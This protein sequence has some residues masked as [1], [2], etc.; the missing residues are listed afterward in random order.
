MFHD[1]TADE[2]M[3]EFV[4]GKKESCTLRSGGHRQNPYGNRRIEDLERKVEE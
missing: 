4:A 3:L 2:R 1:D